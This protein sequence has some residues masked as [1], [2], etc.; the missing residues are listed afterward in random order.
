MVVVTCAPRCAAAAPPPVRVLPCQNATW[1][2]RAKSALA[3]ACHATST[4]AA[5]AVAPD[6]IDSTSRPNAS[7]L[8]CSHSM[9]RSRP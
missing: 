9:A 4:A 3:A 6:R 7:G 2:V 5:G 1:M 8:A